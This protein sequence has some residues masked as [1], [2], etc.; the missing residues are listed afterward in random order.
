MA[1]TQNMPQFLPFCNIQVLVFYY[2]LHILHTCGA[3]GQRGHGLTDGCETNVTHGKNVTLS[4]LSTDTEHY[5]A[6]YLTQSKYVLYYS[7]YYSITNLSLVVVFVLAP[8]MYLYLCY[9]CISICVCTL[10]LFVFVQGAQRAP[11]W[12]PKATSPP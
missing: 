10:Y 12:W 6:L 4:I 7:Y 3:S 11:I 9:I 5:M 1:W 2:L 8:Y